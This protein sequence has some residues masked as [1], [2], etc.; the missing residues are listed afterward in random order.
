MKSTFWPKMRW[1]P[2]SFSSLFPPEIAKNEGGEGVNPRM[3]IS[4][5]EAS[6]PAASSTKAN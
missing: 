5:I 3:K 2:G 4:M 6:V 1:N